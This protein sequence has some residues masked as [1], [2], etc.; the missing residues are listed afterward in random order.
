MIAA[1]AGGVAVGDLLAQTPA[2]GTAGA[3][4]QTLGAP[5]RGQGRGAFPPVQIGP[6]A[7][8]PPEVAIPRPT[9][10]E[11]AQVNDALK[12]LIDSDKSSAKPLLKKF[13]SLMMLQPPRLNVAATFTQTAQRMGP[14]HEGF[15]ETAKQGT[16]ICCCTATR[17]PTGG[18]RATPTRRCSTSTS[19]ASGRRTSRSPATRRRACC[20]ACTTAK[21]RAFS[22]RPSC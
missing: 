19:A 9:P 17:S 7:P 14:R 20:G 13:E 15:V 10:A 16:S 12:K 1:I 5:G 8:V 21:A 3:A 22:R 11:L 4:G 2:A 18:C 6:P